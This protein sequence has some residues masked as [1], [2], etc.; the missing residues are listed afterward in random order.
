MDKNVTVT[1]ASSNLSTGRAR[2]SSI[3]EGGGSTVVNT[4]GTPNT[5]PV[6]P[7]EA[8]AV[9][10]SS[11]KVESALSDQAVTGN[12]VASNLTAH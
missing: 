7:V 11:S 8:P 1:S 10:D 4:D 12:T 6:A 5:T 3:S 9:L 2:S